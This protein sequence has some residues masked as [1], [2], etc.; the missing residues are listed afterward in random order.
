MLGQ[1]ERFCMAIA[2]KRK[3]T[4]GGGGKEE[5]RQ[6]D[7]QQDAG[8]KASPKDLRHSAPLSSCSLELLSNTC[9]YGK[10]LGCHRYRA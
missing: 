3:Q 6:N 2:E 5:E 10:Q 1:R 4:N 8:A 7:E 9:R